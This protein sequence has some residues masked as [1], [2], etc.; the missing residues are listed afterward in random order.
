MQPDPRPA[1][2]TDPELAVSEAADATSGPEMTDPS[3]STTPGTAFATTPGRADQAEP[4]VEVEG[5]GDEA[6]GTDPPTHVADPARRRAILPWAIVVIVVLLL[7]SIAFGLTF[8]PLFRAD[9]IRI[10]GE[11]HLSEAQILRIAGLGSDTNLLHADFEGAQRRL[12][13]QP[14]IAR[15]TISRSL[16]HHLDIQVVE[17][18]PVATAV[19]EGRRVLV[20]IQGVNLGGAGDVRAFPGVTSAEG[21]GDMTRAALRTGAE[22]AA[23]MPPGLSTQIDTIAVDGDGAIVVRTG[24]GILVTYG[25]PTQL[26]AKAQSLKAILAWAAREGKS[27]ATVD[28][29][30]PGAPTVRLRGGASVPAEALAEGSRAVI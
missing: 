9:Q 21:T 15:A 24:G 11:G 19:A 16:P 3:A 6:Q 12:E 22:A 25:G 5:T 10:S 7:G 29:T 8:T 14:W 13:R 27:L 2:A 18:V 17:R 1:A 20:S 23:A 28:V 30:V 4:T 26:E